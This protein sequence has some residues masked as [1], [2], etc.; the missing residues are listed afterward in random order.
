M[1]SHTLVVRDFALTTAVINCHTAEKSE[2]TTKLLKVKKLDRSLKTWRSRAV[3]VASPAR[4]ERRLKMMGSPRYTR[5][6]MAGDAI[7]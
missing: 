7:P 6:V 5:D 1:A 2:K 3:F 4:M